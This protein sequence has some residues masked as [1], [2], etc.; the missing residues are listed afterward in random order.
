MSDYTYLVVLHA[1]SGV[2]L[3]AL[4]TLVLVNRRESVAPWLG[5]VFGVLLLW[6]V[7]YALELAT[8]GLS[9]K[10]FW[11]NVQFI[12]ATILPVLWL[13]TMRIAV[14]APPLPRWLI[15]GIWL[16]AF[17]IIACV[18]VNPGQLF[19]GHP[20]LDT[21]GPIPFV[22][23]DYGALYYFAWA[24]FAWGLLL[25]SL[26]VLIR[27][28]RHGNILVRA[29]SRLLLMA[30]LPPMVAGVLYSAGLL[31][32][33]NFNP[34]VAT[35]SV[36]AVFCA[37]ALVRYRL[38]D[39]TPLARD[40]II[41]QLMDGIIVSDAAGLLVD[42]NPAARAILP[43]VTADALGGPLDALLAGREGFAAA[44]VAA[45]HD[46][47]PPASGD[48]RSGDDED[49]LTLEVADPVSPEG[50]EVR[51]F[52][53]RV[54]PVLRRNGRCVGEALLL[55]DVTGRVELYRSVRR[56]ATTDDLTGLLARRRLLQ[57]GDEEVARCQREARP[58]ATLV[59]D[60]DHFK[61]VNDL[62]G[63]AAG[64]QVLRAVAVACSEQLRVFDRLGRH[65]GDELCAFMP[66]LDADQ[67]LAVA[68]RLR[69][70]VSALS[71][72]W[73][74]KLFRVTVSIGVAVVGARATTTVSGLIEAADGA[75]YEAKRSG[76]NRVAL[77]PA[78]VADT[79]VVV[80][81]RARHLRSRSI[82]RGSREV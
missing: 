41:E 28:V 16:A 21:T 27:A 5:G 30:T 50:C 63:H 22:A 1:A 44:R 61:M 31:P 78:Q 2:A 23:A 75:L 11:A 54:A 70:V 29:R 39:L 18:Y 67:A 73:D 48:W 56:L 46:A 25:A 33:R 32:W 3:V 35:L 62:H 71:I 13:L 10:L 17:I 58:V 76:R 24:P 14:G 51:H 15:G 4:L 79:L 68:E 34:V 26:F 19:R 8:A 59:I 53:V 40:T 64:D 74:D 77:A 72:R 37:V 81:T 43:E 66:G 80:P 9:D 42:F 45:E 47:Q 60:L 20:S 36:A 38:L 55:H 57:L 7:A 6:T 49:T 69:A 82:R 65:G 12:A 52:S